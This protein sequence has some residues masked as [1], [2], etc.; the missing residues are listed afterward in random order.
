MNENMTANLGEIN[1]SISEKKQLI[2]LILCQIPNNGKHQHQHFQHKHEK[3]FL[4]NFFLKN[5]GYFWLKDNISIQHFKPY[6]NSCLDS[7]QIDLFAVIV[8]ALK[9]NLQFPQFVLDMIDQLSKI[10]KDKMF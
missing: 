7:L 1:V 9:L 6:K 2:V 5:G 8:A 3:P 4:W 10:I